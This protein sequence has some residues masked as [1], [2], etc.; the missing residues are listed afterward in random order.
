MK[1][2]NCITTE[3][4]CLKI[5]LFCWKVMLNS[6][7]S[8]LWNKTVQ[9]GKLW[10]TK[11]TVKSPGFHLT[12][13]SWRVLQSQ[14]LKSIQPSARKSDWL[15]NILASFQSNSPPFHRFSFPEPAAMSNHAASWEAGKDIRGLLLITPRVIHPDSSETRPPKALPTHLQ[16]NRDKRP[17]WVHDTYFGLFDGCGMKDEHRG[18]KTTNVYSRACAVTEFELKYTVHQ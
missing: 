6:F 10:K 16:T 8:M 15:G 12:C 14:S 17:N 3:E 13:A 11:P 4:G 18:H 9:N 5:H 7:K 2:R 1:Q